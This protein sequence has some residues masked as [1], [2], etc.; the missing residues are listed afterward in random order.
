M[1]R[2]NMTSEPRQVFALRIAAPPGAPG[3]HALRA[4]LK[5]LLRRHKCRALDIREEQSPTA[6]AQRPDYEPRASN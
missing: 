1:E 6:S 5:E 3:L 2:V 4:V